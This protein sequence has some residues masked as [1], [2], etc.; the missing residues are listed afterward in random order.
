MQK[1]LG[2]VFAKQCQIPT[3]HSFCD[4]IFWFRAKCFM[5]GFEGYGGGGKTFWPLN[6]TERSDRRLFVFLETPH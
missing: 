2:Y 5:G 4:I 1:K 6:C 3:Y